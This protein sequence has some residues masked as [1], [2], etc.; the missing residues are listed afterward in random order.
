MNRRSRSVALALLALSA[1]S[2]CKGSES[3]PPRSSKVAKRSAE[4]KAA[5]DPASPCESIAQQFRRLIKEGAGSCEN[6]SDC[7]C[8]P[9]A[10]DCGGATDHMTWSRMQTLLRLFGLAG[11]KG[12]PRCAAAGPC[13]A[14]CVAGRC[15]ASAQA[16]IEARLAPTPGECYI[17]STRCEFSMHL[18]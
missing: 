7:V 11:C 10:V 14:Q 3:Q 18:E 6:D 9:A 13:K 12:P 8:Y 1:L 2:S 5:S 4:Q 15:R 17:P 16:A